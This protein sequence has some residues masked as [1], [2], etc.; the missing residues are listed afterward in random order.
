MHDIIIE[1]PART[2]GIIRP[3]GNKNAALPIIAAAMLTDEQVVLHNLPNILDAD[4]M[5]NL[6]RQI[7]ASVTRNGTDVTIHAKNIEKSYCKYNLQRYS[8]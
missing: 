4:A 3:G 6:A 7:G 8:S 5:L 1:G 2:Q